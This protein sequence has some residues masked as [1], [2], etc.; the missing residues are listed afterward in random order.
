MQVQVHTDNHIRGSAEL[1]EWVEGVAEGALGRFGDRVTRVVVQLTD[2][3]GGTKSGGDDKRCVMEARLAGLQPI[4]VKHHAGMLEQAVNGAA[5]K[6]EK[7]V[8]H[9]VER[10][11]DPRGRPSFGGDQTV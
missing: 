9:V 8:E 6:L 4:T 11:D 7:A 10:R 5:D 2:V 1:T 3:N